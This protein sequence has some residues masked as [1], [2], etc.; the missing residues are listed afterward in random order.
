MIKLKDKFFLK[1]N[2]NSK[3][4]FIYKA[5]NISVEEFEDLV[6]KYNG[7]ILSKVAKWDQTYFESKDDC[8]KFVEKLESIL[9]FN[10]MVE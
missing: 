4:W 7:K 1:F 9:I 3:N 2:G 5:L 6:E 10:R 8:E